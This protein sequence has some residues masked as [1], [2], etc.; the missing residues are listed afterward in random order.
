M[1]T[2]FFNSG[3]EFDTRDNLPGNV[4]S[5]LELYRFLIK[6]FPLLVILRTLT[7]FVLVTHFL[8]VVVVTFFGY[9]SETFEFV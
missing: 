1:F 9:F 3:H 5:F 2:I 4:V 6:V 7:N 8:R